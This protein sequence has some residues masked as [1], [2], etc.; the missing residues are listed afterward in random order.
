MKDSKNQL[1]KYLT[2]A[3]WLFEKNEYI[4]LQNACEHM[5]VSLPSIRRYLKS[6]QSCEHIIDL[7]I[8]Y[9]GLTITGIKVKH[10]IPYKYVPGRL[11]QPKWPESCTQKVFGSAYFWQKL[12]RSSWSN[13]SF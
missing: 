9:S 1:P 5:N 2:L 7:S 13:I 3:H 8:R 6:M 10:I 12:T 11:P 4:T